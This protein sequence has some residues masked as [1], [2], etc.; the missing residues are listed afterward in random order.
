MNLILNDGT[1]LILS[2]IGA[3]HQSGSVI[4]TA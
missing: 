2:G 4:T 1:H 3:I